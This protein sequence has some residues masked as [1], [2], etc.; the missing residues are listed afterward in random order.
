VREAETHEADDRK[1][2][3]EVELRNRLDT[4]VYQMEKQLRELGDRVP[5]GSLG[6]VDSASPRP[7]GPSGTGRPTSCGAPRTR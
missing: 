4:L 2:K 3:E 1:R 5:A 7:G 6:E